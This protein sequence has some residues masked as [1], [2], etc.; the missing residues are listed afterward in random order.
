LPCAEVVEDAQLNFASTSTQQ[1]APLPPLPLAPIS[2]SVSRN[3]DLNRASRLP[4]KVLA[5]SQI[6]TDDSADYTANSMGAFATLNTTIDDVAS[7]E[8]PSQIL[9][10]IHTPSRQRRA[11]VSG[12]SLEAPLN[13]DLETG[14]PSKRREKSKSHGNLFQQHIAPISLL[15]AELNKGRSLISSSM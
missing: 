15:E 12:R 1:L 2:R 9:P 6:F 7:S 14:S 11:T 13:L 3:R 8:G 4:R 10:Q 5:A